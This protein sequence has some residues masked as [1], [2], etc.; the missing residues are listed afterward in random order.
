MPTKQ[1]CRELFLAK[2]IA[3][4]PEEHRRLTRRIASQLLEFLQSRP[5]GWLHSYVSEGFRNEIDTTYIRQLINAALPVRPR[6]VAPRMSPG[7]HQMSHYI[8]DDDTLLVPNRW[9][10]REP[11]PVLSQSVDIS[12]IDAMLV[13][14]LGYDGQGH[15]VGY[16]GGYYDR[17]LAE[18][19]PD[20]WKIGLSFFEPV[21]AIDD[22]GPWDIKL[23][24]CVT[25]SKVYRWAD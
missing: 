7:S 12:E 1:Q 16:G 5:I 9:G 6:W 18:C 21:E 10:I 2:R 8:W 3:I 17:L 25:P 4:G 19:R 24:L 22:T 13:P 11:D 14:L 20:A 23:D 15:R